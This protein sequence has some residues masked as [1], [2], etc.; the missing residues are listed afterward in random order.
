M[1][2]LGLAVRW[3]HLAACLVLVGASATI[4]FAGRSDRPTALRWERRLLV[5]SH[6]LAALALVSGVALLLFHTAILEGRATAA[7]DPAALGRVLFETHGGRVWLVRHGLLLL[8]AA[9]LAIR[10]TVDERV[11]WGAAR[12]E[13]LLLGGAA[14]ALVGAAGHAAAVEPDAALAIAV[15][16]VHL[17][18][19]GVWAG[20]LIPLAVL[21]GAAARA[22]GADARPY[23]VRAARRFS[24]WALVAV[25]VLAGTGAANAAA[26]VGSVAGL[27]GTT[28]GRLLLGK[29]ALLVPI[30]GLA[31]ANRRLHLPRL[32][33]DGPTVGRPAMR[34]LAR[35]VA[36]EGT[37]ALALFAFVA[38]MSLT[39]PARHDAPA[40]PFSF[41]LS[42]AVLEDAPGLATR[43]LVGSQ[44]AVL[45]G[46]ILLAA[47]LLRAWRL[48]LAAGA[49]VLLGA[50]AALALPPL[51]IDAYPTTYLRPS[52]PY[53]AA[54]IAAGE[55]LYRAN[56]AVCHGPTGAGDG[57]GGLRLPR[58]PADLRSPHTAQHTAGDLFWWITHGI[59]RGEMP[60]FGARLTEEERWDLINF[61]RALSSGYA[62][63]GLGPGVGVERPWLVA[64]D[65]TFAVGP[66]PAR[67]LK[68]YRGRRIVLLVLYS[69]PGSRP[70][71]SQLAERYDVLA[72]L[73]AEVIAVPA[74]GAA[75]AIRRLGAEPR[76][77]FPVVTDGASAI[78][79]AYRLFAGPAH[80]EVLID[81]QG[82]VR[83][84]ARGGGGAA[85][86][87][88]A[89]LAE[90][91]QLNEEKA[92]GPAPEEHVH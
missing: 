32:A 88:N 26:H 66:T 5:R 68:D 6:A 91:Q 57:P 56:C 1:F 84:I 28:Y 7:F 54:S 85:A 61:L 86:D 4:L 31:A 34:V 72:T 33:G 90:I 63:R 50:G 77:L 42:T 3:V 51:A 70:R 64:P 74:D 41:R 40:W 62:A 14:L 82:Y 21:L 44:V 65:F 19:A 23:A 80:A 67:A 78:L 36:V 60:A 15:D 27:V 58:P 20:A 48:P 59:P 8:L 10:W 92:P 75:D 71:I 18:A 16:G 73:G 83:A 87:P 13:A 76:I 37:L 17:L 81:R 11:D 38:A 46:V 69:L 39:P 45:G 9:F 25:L 24:R 89:L 43:A 53:Q 29:L 12:G 52:V 79:A 47:L 30:L 2:A 22:E 35:F 49:G 55:T